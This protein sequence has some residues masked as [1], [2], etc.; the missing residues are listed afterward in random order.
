MF[1]RRISCEDVKAVIAYGEIIE[2]MPDDEP[3]PSYLILDFVGGQPVHVVLSQDVARQ[4]CYVV[5]A[6][7]P[8]LGLW[9]D[10]FRT[11]R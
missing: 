3:F 4:T 2:E 5:T 6:Y 7:V 8:N 1:F 11:R 9:N 10:D